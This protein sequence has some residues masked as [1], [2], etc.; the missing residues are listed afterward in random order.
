MDLF[1]VPTAIP[2]EGLDTERITIPSIMPRIFDRV[3]D[4]I[5]S[6]AREHKGLI[7]AFAPAATNYLMTAEDAFILPSNL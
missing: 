7:T 5:V 3:L 1:Y 2:F 6:G 4:L